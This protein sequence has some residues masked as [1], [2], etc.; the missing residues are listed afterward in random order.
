MHVIIKKSLF[1]RKLNIVIHNLW[2]IYKYIQSWCDKWWTYQFMHATAYS[3]WKWF[4]E[5][6]Q[7]VFVIEMKCIWLENSFGKC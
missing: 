2:Y 3:Q 5:S 1:K 4:L 7:E 6:D